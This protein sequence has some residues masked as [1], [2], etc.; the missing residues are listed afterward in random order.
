[1]IMILLKLNLAPKFTL[2]FI[3]I[4]ALESCLISGKDLIILTCCNDT[5]LTLN[6]ITGII[7]I[8][9]K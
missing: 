4:F 9:K 2:I 8:E 6:T 7:T 5:V 1:M 3:T